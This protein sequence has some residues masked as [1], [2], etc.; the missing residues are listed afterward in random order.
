MWNSGEAAKGVYGEENSISDILERLLPPRAAECGPQRNDESMAE[1]GANAP[2]QMPARLCAV[3]RLRRAAARRRQ[4]E[5]QGEA[6]VLSPERACLFDA[7]IAQTVPLL[8]KLGLQ[9]QTSRNALHGRIV[10]YTPYL[11]LTPEDAPEARA[12]L[13]RLL[14]TAAEVSLYPVDSGNGV[15]LELWY[16]LFE[17]APSEQFQ[18]S[19]RRTDFHENGDLL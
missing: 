19:S 15:E 8:E 14:H 6:Q 18:A 3:E 2:Q 17:N 12:A 13:D 1:D 7:L 9:A 11:L 10:L 4:Q 5:A 16:D